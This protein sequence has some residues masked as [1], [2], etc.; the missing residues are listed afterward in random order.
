M[1]LVHET[2]YFLHL[3]NDSEEVLTSKGYLLRSQRL[4]RIMPPHS[5][6]LIKNDTG[7]Q[8][9]P[10]RTSIEP[11]IHWIYSLVNWESP[12]DSISLSQIA[13]RKYCLV[14]AQICR[15]VLKPICSLLLHI[16]FYTYFKRGW[17]FSK[18]QI[19][20]LLSDLQS[21]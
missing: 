20:R 6:S 12:H 18:T 1:R 14:S 16:Q 3:V 9:Q 2:L 8:I 15:A 7:L 17:K 5:S 21:L 19:L 10:G 11:T 4:T 13:S